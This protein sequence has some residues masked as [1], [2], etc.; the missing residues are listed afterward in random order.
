ML[1]LVRGN[2]LHFGDKI[3]RCAIGKNGFSENKKEGDGA[4]PLGVFAL[5][6]CWY[7]ADK[8][9][10]PKTALPLRVVN[11]NDG[12]CDSPDAPE[13]NTHV[14]L[15]PSP[16]GRGQGEG[17]YFYN[18]PELIEFSRGLRKNQTAPEMKLWSMLR[19]RQM[20]GLKFRRQH[21]IEGY[22]ADFCCEEIK[23]IIELDGNQHGTDEGMEKDAMRSHT[24]EKAGYRVIRFSNHEMAENFEGVLETIFYVTS[25][26]ALTPTLSQRERGY[27]FEQLFRADDVYDIIVPLG[28]NDAPIVAG[29]GSAIFMHVAKPDYTGT[30]GCV[31]LALPDLLEVLAGCSAATRIDIR[32]S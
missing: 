32:K 23:L 12:W 1:L 17:F 24:L 30:E 10:M 14:K 25:S 7:R 6:E 28:Y 19:N 4:T 26:S 2:E 20:N 18:Q 5:R 11:E 9:A 22:I 27:S 3:Y 15:K 13:Y 16:S 21:P 29:R 8:I 31:A